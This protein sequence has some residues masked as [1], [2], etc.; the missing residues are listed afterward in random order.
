MFG[1]QIWNKQFLSFAKCQNFVQR[2]S[3]ARSRLRMT[4]GRLRAFGAKSAQLA[5]FTIPQSA[6]QTAPFTQGSLFLE[7]SL[8]AGG[9][10]R[11]IL[12]LR[13]RMTQPGAS[14]VWGRGLHLIR[15]AFGAPRQ[16]VKQ[17]Q[18]EK[19]QRASAS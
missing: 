15:R 9:T 16:I 2:D 14:C 1:L 4:W 10:V 7:A 3:S 13:L 5:D 11:E 17:V 6:P 18:Q 12:R 8:R 19:L